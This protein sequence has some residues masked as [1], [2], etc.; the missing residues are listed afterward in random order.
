M[1]QAPPTSNACVSL[2]AQSAGVVCTTCPTGAGGSVAAGESFASFGEIAQGRRADG[3]DFLITL[4]VDLWSRCGVVCEPVVG[5]SR[6]TTPLAKSRRVAEAYLRA[7]GLET[8]IGLRL[9]LRRDMPV[10]KGLSSSTADMLAVLRACEALFGVAAGEAFICRLFAAIEPHDALHYPTCVA[11]NHR[12]GRPLACFD[13]VPDFRIIAVDAGGV[14][15]TQAYNRR[16]RFGQARIAEDQALYER[17]LAS[18]AARDDTAIARCAQAA[19]ELHL[20]RTGNPFLAGLLKQARQ[21]DVLGVVTAHSGT[22]AGLLLPGGADAE[23]LVRVAR[24]VAPLGTVFQTR[25]LRLPKPS[26]PTA[27]RPA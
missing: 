3:E 12:R 10:G 4:P 5:A 16:L 15:C 26:L 18:F 24:R 27:R 17:V 2:D 7:L 8:G 19:T 25:T 21:P 1:L 6:V 14:V 13:Y 9:E 20:A 11:Y 22:C 23:V